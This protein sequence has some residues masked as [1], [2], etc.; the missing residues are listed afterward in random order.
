M[1]LFQSD[2]T[3]KS[4]QQISPL[5]WLN[6]VCLDAPLVAVSWQWLFAR[7]FQVPLTNSARLTLF[8]TAWLIYLADRLADSWALDR[9]GA[10]IA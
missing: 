7:A 3:A 10:T 6:L 1:K 4:R 8:L 2:H 9:N 5:V